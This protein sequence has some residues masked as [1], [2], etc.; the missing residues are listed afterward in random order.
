MGQSPR[1]V[2]SSPPDLD[3]WMRAGPVQ[4]SLLSSNHSV[5]TE[6]ES[7]IPHMMSHLLIANKIRQNVWPAW[8]S[9][10]KYFSFIPR[11][12]AICCKT[13]GL[14]CYS[15]LC[16]MHEEYFIVTMATVQTLSSERNTLISC[17]CLF[18]LKK[19]HK[20]NLVWLTIDIPEHLGMPKQQKKTAICVLEARNATQWSRLCACL[21]ILAIP[22]FSVLLTYT[23]KSTNTAE[24][25]E[26]DSSCKAFHLPCKV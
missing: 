12:S 13:V 14:R 1:G 4:V 24:N 25:L 26:S 18:V 17:L 5:P 19:N 23:K 20:L 6:V 21:Q 9:L 11:T 15:L 8:K 3:L 2:G 10:R 7:H 16:K 22:Y